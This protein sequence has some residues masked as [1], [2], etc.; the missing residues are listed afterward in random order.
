MVFERQ[1]TAAAIRNRVREDALLKGARIG[2]PQEAMAAYEAGAEIADGQLMR[3]YREPQILPAC[4]N[5]DYL[6]PIPA[7]TLAVVAGVTPRSNRERRRVGA[8]PVAWM[9]PKMSHQSV[10][11]AGA[12]PAMTGAVAMP[13]SKA[14]IRECECPCPVMPCS[15]PC[16]RC[17]QCAGAARSP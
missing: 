12:G 11:P 7:S 9:P 5:D 15:L 3:Y 16:C 14:A 13:D 8:C 4:L 1:L 10:I 17:R 6:R 2:T